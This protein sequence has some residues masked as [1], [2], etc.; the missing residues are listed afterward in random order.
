MPQLTLRWHLTTA[1][2]GWLTAAV[3]PGFVA[4]TAA[5]ALLNL[6]DLIGARTMS[7]R[8]AAGRTRER[9]LLVASGFGVALATRFVTGLPLAARPPAMKMMAT[10]YR[11]RRGLAIGTVVGALTVGKATLFLVHVPRR[12]I[13]PRSCCSRR[14]AARW[15]ARRW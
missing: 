15:S 4:G 2:A 3:Q 12:V 11:E 9:A 1:Q 5:A 6:G 10:W 8:A 7:R 13:P 14:A